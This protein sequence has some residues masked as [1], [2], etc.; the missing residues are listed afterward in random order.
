[1]YKTVK[2][3][4][5]MIYAVMAMFIYILTLDVLVCRLDGFQQSHTGMDTTTGAITILMLLCV[6]ASFAFYAVIS[7]PKK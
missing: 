4:F 5:A 6:A 3:I 2:F 1:M 7:I